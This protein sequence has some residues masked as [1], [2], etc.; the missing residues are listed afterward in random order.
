VNALVCLLVIGDLGSV[1]KLSLSSLQEINPSR[2]CVT[3]NPSGK[4]WLLSITPEC[5][6]SKICFHDSVAEKFEFKYLQEKSSYS[7]YRSKDFRILTLLKW[8]LL[9]ASLENH[10]ESKAVLF[11]DLDVYWMDDPDIFLSHLEASRSLMFVQDDASELRPSW[12]CTGVMFWKNTQ[13]SLVML[14]KLREIHQERIEKGF[15]QD[16]E[17]TF[18]RYI[19]EF[20]NS[21]EFERLPKEQF[22]VGRHFKVLLF[23]GKATDTKYCFHANYLTGLN[24]KFDSLDAVDSYIRRG[25]FPWKELIKILTIPVS[26]RLKNGTLRRL[27]VK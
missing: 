2:I 24:Q 1:G 21:L 18:N 3:S 25:K 16:D 8:D 7:E 15:L 12:C 10:P 5:L 22:L 4:K 27:G 14:K 9:I 13:N 19:S 23:S 6:M 20:P 26:R 17:D 11:S